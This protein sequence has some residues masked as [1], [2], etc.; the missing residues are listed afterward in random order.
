MIFRD[1]ASTGMAKM[2]QMGRISDS[3]PKVAHFVYSTI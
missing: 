3:V 2:I 1:C